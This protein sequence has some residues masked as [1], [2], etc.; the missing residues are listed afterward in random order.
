[1]IEGQRIRIA[2]TY[3]S[4]N[5]LDDTS[6][7]DQLAIIVQYLGADPLFRNTYEVRLISGPASGETRIVTR[8]EM[9]GA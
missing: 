5:N 6:A 9:R 4:S 7:R 2:S 3:G 8:N 1:M